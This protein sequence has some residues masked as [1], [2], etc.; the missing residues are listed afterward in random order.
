MKMP[1]DFEVFAEIGEQKEQ[2]M[3]VWEGQENKKQAVAEDVVVLR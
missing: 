3:A 2:E 1:I